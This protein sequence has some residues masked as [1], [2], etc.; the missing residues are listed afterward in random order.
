[1]KRH[2]YRFSLLLSLALLAGCEAQDYSAKNV[3]SGFK[4][5][6]DWVR[7]AFGEPVAQVERDDPKGP[8]P[9][10]PTDPRPE[11]R[12]QKTR[13]AMIADLQADRTTS[14]KITAAIDKSGDKTRYLAFNGA[15]PAA[16]PISLTAETVSLPDGVRDLD[17]VDRTRLGD[18]FDVATVEFKEGSAE[19]PD[20]L[21]KSLAQ[22]AR[23][24]GTHLDAR[25]VGYS[26][27]DRLVLPGKGPHE[28]NR[29]LAELRA[30][31]VADALAHM[32]VAPNKLIVGSAAEAERK[33]GDKVEIIIDY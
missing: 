12:P 1:L 19:L 17:S 25:I 29:Y 13:D 15:P 27:S 10:P 14:A 28:A 26:G 2:P 3:S 22:A 18:W 16:Q 4:G 20:D 9:N 23:L 11:L 21:E 6:V 24:A 30:R 8:F 7:D 33:S 32:G 5:G 31:K